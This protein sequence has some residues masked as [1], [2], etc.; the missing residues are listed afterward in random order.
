MDAR[1]EGAARTAEHMALVRRSVAAIV[2]SVVVVQWYSTVLVGC[3]R[4]MKADEVSIKVLR[5]EGTGSSKL[6]QTL[7]SFVWR[8]SSMSATTPSI[9]CIEHHT[10]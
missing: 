3:N 9:V 6:H 4:M 2:L 10:R 8:Q 7:T 5:E 1:M